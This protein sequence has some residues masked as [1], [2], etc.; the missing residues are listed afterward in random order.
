V[1]G[2]RVLTRRRAWSASLVLVILA[3][4]LSGVLTASSTQRAQAICTAP[5]QPLVI[6]RYNASGTAVAS[7]GAPYPGSTCNNDA[8][9]SGLVLDPVTDGSCAYV[10][11]LEPL[12]YLAQ[13]GASCTTGSWSSYGY[14]DA[15][16]T[17]SVFVSTR[18]SYLP[19][20]WRLSSGY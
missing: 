19:D 15:I 13:Q 17:N 10:Y 12:S 7:E 8:R 16:G 9:Y 1:E 14:N 3:V 6:T 5:G 20:E 2:E 18:P 11:Y 4:T